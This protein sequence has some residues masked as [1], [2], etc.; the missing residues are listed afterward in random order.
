MFEERATFHKPLEKVEAF[1][2]LN[3]HSWVLA[4]GSS[5]T[6]TG[7]NWEGGERKEGSLDAIF[8]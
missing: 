6:K 4:L 2:R 5:F 3:F 7:Q 1:L 8:T